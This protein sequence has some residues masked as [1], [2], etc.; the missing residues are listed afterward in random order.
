MAYYQTTG[1]SY[2]LQAGAG[3]YGYAMFFMKEEAVEALGTADGVKVG[4]DRSA[5]VVD[6]GMA[7]S[8][9]TTNIQDDSYACIFT[10]KGLMPG[11][12]LQGNKFDQINK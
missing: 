7:K 10:R 5:L 11:L 8:R 4:V 1:A 12:V 9:T 2:S 3:A 6:E